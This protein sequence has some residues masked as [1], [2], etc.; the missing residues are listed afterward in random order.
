[1]KFNFALVVFLIII[2]ILII[3]FI[4]FIYDS[5]KYTGSILFPQFLNEG[6]TDRMLRKNVENFDSM[7]Q[8]SVAIIDDSNVPNCKFPF[9][10]TKDHNGKKLNII[11]VSAPFRT[12]ED[13]KFYAEQ[14]EKG[15]LFCGISSYL[16]FPGEIINPYEDKFHKTR[17]HDYPAMVKAWLH[18][19]RPEKIPDNL[20]QSG[21]PMMLMAEAD[22]KDTDGYYKPDPNIKKEYDFMYICLDDDDSKDSKCQPGWQWYNRNWDLAKKCLEVM[23]RDYHLKGIIVGRTNCEFT[24][25]CSGIVK[26]VP[27]M[28]FHTF[29]KEMQ[30]CKWL[31]VPNI[32]DA[33][34]RVMTESMCYNMPVLTN[35]N[36]IGGWHNVMPG[37]TGEFFTDENDIIP[38]LDK[39][40]KNYD[41]Y[42]PREWY[43][44]NRGRKISGK[45]LADFLKTNF[46]EI[47]NPNVE[48]ADI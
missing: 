22:L 37:V 36:I 46:P 8:N 12:E 38:A 32:S 9:K 18:C 44:A 26:V 20:K 14:K 11:M 31:F 1:M 4:K 35:Y 13:E 24:N 5:H 16:D 34:P 29:Q 21:L 25:F 42:T 15:M 41:Q 17:G 7:A 3:E 30:K 19:F 43:C 28:D 6:M 39:L 2:I 23:C 33:S 40:T 10:N 45:Q 27:F 48:W 47:N